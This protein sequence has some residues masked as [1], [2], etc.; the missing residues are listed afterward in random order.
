MTS[1]VA[2]LPTLTGACPG[3]LTAAVRRAVRSGGS[4]QQTASSVVAALRG[5]LPGPAC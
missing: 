5:H 1:S 4:W 2:E 3:P